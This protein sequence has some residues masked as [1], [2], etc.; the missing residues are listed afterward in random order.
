MEDN[1]GYLFAAFVI[2][3]TALFAYLL[4][5]SR[6]QRRLRQEIDLLK[7]VLGEKAGD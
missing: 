3:W 4:S 6:R 7:E 2:V 5:L 1:L